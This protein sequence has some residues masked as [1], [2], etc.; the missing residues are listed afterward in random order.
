MIVI[1]NKY[2]DRNYRKPKE[3]QNVTITDSSDFKEKQNNNNIENKE[4]KSAKRESII[5]DIICN[6]PFIL[7]TL[8]RGNRIFIF[9]AINFWFSD[10]L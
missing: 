9:V 2:Y 10:Y 7:V 3:I 6:I 1:P 8:Y 4:M 5:K